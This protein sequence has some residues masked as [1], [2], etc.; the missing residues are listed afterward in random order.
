MAKWIAEEEDIVVCKNPEI[1]KGFITGYMCSECGKTLIEPM[2]DGTFS[3]CASVKV[4]PNCG[5]TME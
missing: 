5:A 2:L 4:C 1:H 3:I